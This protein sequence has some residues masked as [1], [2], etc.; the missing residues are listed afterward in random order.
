MVMI[1]RYG[2]AHEPTPAGWTKRPM[3]GWQGERNRVIFVKED[4]QM[5]V[6]IKTMHHR[7]APDTEVE[8]AEKVAPRV[9]GLRLKTLRYLSQYGAAT[10]EEVAAGLDEWLY[11]VKPRITELARYGLVQDSGERKLNV[12]KRREIIWQITEAG[13]E[14]LNG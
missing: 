8:A 11:S 3:A 10:G 6:D 14:L 1:C 7:D 2:K 12:R 5:K 13:K 4:D 9:T